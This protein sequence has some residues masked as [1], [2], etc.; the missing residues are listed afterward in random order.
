MIS[1]K[2]GNIYKISPQDH[3][4]FYIKI[5]KEEHSMYDYIVLKGTDISNRKGFDKG[6]KFHEE[7]V[8]EE[9]TEQ[10]YLVEIL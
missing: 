7:Y 1:I 5:I 10:E 2:I 8:T 3:D 6:S 4:E 9:F